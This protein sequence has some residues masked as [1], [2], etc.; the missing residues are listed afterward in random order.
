MASTRRTYLADVLSRISDHSGQTRRRPS[1]N[2]IRTVTIPNSVLPP[3]GR[4]AGCDTSTIFMERCGKTHRL[5]ARENKDGVHRSQRAPMSGLLSA[6]LAPFTW[7]LDLLEIGVSDSKR[8]EAAVGA[9]ADVEGRV[10]RTASA[11]DSTAGAASC[12]RC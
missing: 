2:P 9:R 3:G 4:T 6:S 1:A 10:E 12:Q 5:N 11:T 7:L 8:Y